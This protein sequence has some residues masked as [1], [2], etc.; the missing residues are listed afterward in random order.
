[1]YFTIVNFQMKD[2]NYEGG[3]RG[4]ACVFSPLIT[5]RSRVSEQTFHITDWLPTLYSVA[6][7]NLT[8]LKDI[9]GLNQWPTI[10]DDDVVSPRVST[11]INIDE[12]R[13]F[14][15]A[16]VGK[17]KL[18]RGAENS[19]E[20]CYGDDGEDPGY[21]E[22]RAEE[23]LA[24]PAGLAIARLGFDHQ[25][26]EVEVEQLREKSTVRCKPSTKS[27][28]NCTASCLFDVLEDPCETRDVKA[29]HPE[30]RP[31]F[32][33]LL[34]FRINKILFIL[35][36]LK[37]WSSYWPGTRSS[38]YPRTEKNSTSARTPITST[39]PGCPG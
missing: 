28:M 11:L 8:D 33:F 5:S 21:P 1:M 38:C 23:V 17:F 19:C 30:V 29:D 12:I 15:A 18:V 9:D 7:G 22:Y 32:F 27:S 31:S 36:S 24:S 20:D 2:T 3:V 6:G 26:S 16:R 39:A 37:S 14:Q 13:G 25:V 34:I 35:R 4:V 10:L